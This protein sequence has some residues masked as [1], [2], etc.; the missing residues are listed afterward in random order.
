MNYVTYSFGI[1]SS[2]P[3][4]RSPGYCC[5]KRGTIR[6]T[7]GNTNNPWKENFHPE[8]AETERYE[9]VTSH[10]GRHRLT[11]YLRVEQDVSKEL[12]KYIRGDKDGTWGEKSTIDTYIHTYYE[13]VEPVYRDAIF[14]LYI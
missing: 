14:K 13:N 5:Q 12:V 6:W 10:F 11:T 2:G 1:C 4:T 3:I 9:A 7:E 8:Y